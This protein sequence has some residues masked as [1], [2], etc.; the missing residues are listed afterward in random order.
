MINNNNISNISFKGYDAIPLRAIYMQGLRKR[1]EKSIFREM[2]RVIEKEGIDLFINTSNH[3]ITQAP[4]QTRPLKAFSIW[5]QDRKIFTKDKNGKHLLWNSKE[6]VMP[7]N[8]ITPLEDFKIQPETYIP[9]G[10]NFYLGYKENGEKWLIVNTTSIT[11]N[12]NFI[13]FGDKPTQEHLSEL[14]DINPKNMT[15]IIDI[16]ADLDEI[17]RPIGYPYVLVNDYREA[18]EM[19]EIMHKKFP[20]AYETYFAMEK[21]LTNE[22][23]KEATR[24]NTCDEN[25]KIL[26]ENGFIPIKIGAHFLHDINFINAIAMKNKNGNITYITNSTKR[27]YPELHFLEE[28]FDKRLK[29]KAPQIDTTYYVSGG[30]RTYDEKNSDGAAFLYG[31]GLI[32]RN[33]IM[34]ILANRGG[35]IHCMCAEIPDFSRL[36]ASFKKA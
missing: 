2:Q 6:E 18:N 5:A 16:S 26:K 28:L 19:L 31:N 36:E 35:G 30:R 3:A 13:K 23:E 11:T 33:V 25:C 32:E 22:I 21:F 15:G 4:T 17:I 20:K 9:R 29:E 27:S 1:G 7:Q 8:K 10:G 12:E 34:D 24:G 14:L